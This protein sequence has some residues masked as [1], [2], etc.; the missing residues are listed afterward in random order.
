M[1]KRTE[2][3]VFLMA[4]PGNVAGH[5]LLNPSRLVLSRAAPSKFAVDNAFGVVG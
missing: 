4:S 3:L 5:S 2:R 1:R